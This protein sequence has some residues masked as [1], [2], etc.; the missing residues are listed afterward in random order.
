MLT[1]RCASTSL[2][3]IYSTSEEKKTK[4]PH[5]NVGEVIKM[6]YMVDAMLY[7][8]AKELHELGIECETASKLIRGDE[9]SSVK[10]QTQT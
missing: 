9:D 8:L 2:I 7:G 5:K 1:N 10:Y 4:L 6:K 3:L